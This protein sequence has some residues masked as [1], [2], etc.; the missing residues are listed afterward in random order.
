MYGM[1][2]S[3]LRSSTI[4]MWLHLSTS[5][6]HTLVA[7]MAVSVKQDILASLL[8]NAQLNLAAKLC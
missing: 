8:Y 2:G 5:T 7:N 6:A 4:T 3:M 1:Y